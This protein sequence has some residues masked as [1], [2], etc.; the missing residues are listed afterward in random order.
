[1]KNKKCP[2]CGKSKNKIFWG[3]RG[4]PLAKCGNCSMVWD[5]QFEQENEAQ[6]EKLYFKNDNPKGGYANYFDGMAINKKTFAHRLKKIEKKLG[7][8]GKLLDVGC[9]LGDC[10]MVARDLGWED[11]QGLELSEY[12]SSF[13]KK[14]GLNV[15]RGTLFSKKFPKNYF[16]VVT[17][18]DVIE[19]VDDPIKQLKE[20]YRILK[21]GG[22]VLL[23]TPDIGGFWS[24][25]LGS[26]WY[27]Y[28]P[29]E[30]LLYFS[31]EPT[32]LALKKVGFKKIQ[33]YKTFHV[34]S[35]EYIFNRLRFYS[36][37]LFGTMLKVA[38][39]SN[40]KNLPFRVY[41]GELEAWGVKTE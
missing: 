39:K 7:K 27:H 8:K 23:V 22:I 10:L 35:L 40:L 41:A 38:R 31:Q 36:P 25:L 32:C 16:D 19:H 18:F 28:K 20:I 15:S 21:P 4:Y 33:T 5:Y 14:R 26:N 1:M 17:M 9:A 34:M 12:A 11:C 3:Q 2:V 13:A 24:K 30:H 29:G 6:Y 37:V